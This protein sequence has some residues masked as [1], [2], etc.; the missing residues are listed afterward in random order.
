MVNYFK[1]SEMPPPDMWVSPTAPPGISLG[2]G[3]TLTVTRIL[4]FCPLPAF[5][6]AQDHLSLTRLWITCPKVQT[7]S[8]SASCCSSLLQQEYGSF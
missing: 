7:A 2:A 6:S 8:F 1:T 5:V 4:R 3:H